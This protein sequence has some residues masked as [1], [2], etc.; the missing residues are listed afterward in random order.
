MKI[1][2]EIYESVKA[3][4]KTV[5]DTLGVNVA[6]ADGGDT[7]LKTMWGLLTI[8]SRNRAYGDEHPAFAQ[9]VWARVLPCDGRDYC[10][11]YANGCN[12]THVATMLRNIKAELAQ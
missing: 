12:D 3:D 1:S 7:G 5:A 9:G 6:T 11:Y 8:V 2:P 4:I 10:F